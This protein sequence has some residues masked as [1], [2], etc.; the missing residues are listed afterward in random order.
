MDYFPTIECF[1]IGTYSVSGPEQSYVGMALLGPIIFYECIINQIL[2]SVQQTFDGCKNV[3]SWS[4]N[5][6]HNFR[7]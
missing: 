7:I 3:C 2:G 5:I 1:D 4:L 6:S